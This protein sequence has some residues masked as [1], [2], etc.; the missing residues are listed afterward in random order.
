LP[1][2]T[3]LGDATVADLIAARMAYERTA[4][5]AEAKAKNAELAIRLKGGDPKEGV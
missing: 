3:R 1:N 2:G 5:E 4:R